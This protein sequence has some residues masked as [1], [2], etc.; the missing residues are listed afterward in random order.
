MKTKHKVGDEVISLVSRTAPNEQKL[1]KGK[2]YFVVAVIFCPHCGHQFVNVGQDTNREMY[3]CSECLHHNDAHNCFWTK[4][5][6][7]A[8]KKHLKMA[9]QN[10]VSEEDYENAAFIHAILEANK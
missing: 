9:L 3:S 7:F 1:E 6:N 8:T 10:A 4:A 2:D 5:E